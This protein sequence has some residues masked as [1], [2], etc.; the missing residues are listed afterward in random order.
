MTDCVLLVDDEAAVRTALAQ[1]MDLADIDATLAATGEEALAT[2][3][4]DWPGAVVTDMRMPGLSGL[5]LLAK[6]RDLDPD[7]PVVILT[8]QGD[9]PM[10][11]K[12]MTEGAYDFL[13]KPCP[14]DRLVEIVRHA[15]EKR[16]LVL[17][18][19]ALRDR[20]E[21]AEAGALAGNI[22]GEAAATRDYRARLIRVAEAGLDVLILGETGAGKELAARA[23][24][25]RSDRAAGPFVA[26]NCGALP[27]EL[28]A[29]ELLGH[30]KGAFTGA[31]ARRIGKFEHANGGAIFLDEIESMPRDLQVRLLR[32]LQERE[33]ERLGANTPV[34]LDIRVIAASKA[35]LKAEAAAGRFREDLFYRLDASRLRV[36]PLRERLED[37]PLLFRA[38]VEA[39]AARRGSAPPE[40]GP[41]L[42]MR[43]AAH[44]WPGN[45]RELKNAAERY[46]MGL[47]LQL[48]ADTDPAPKGLAEQV[49]AFERAALAEALRHAAG[50]AAEA[51]AALGLPRKTFYDKLTRHGLRAEDF[52]A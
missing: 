37:A 1:T 24:H 7:I 17:E 32:I 22:L 3:S 13:E 26:V 5:D 49:E 45:V 39:A 18:N 35:D 15:C 43:L 19:R 23:I 51:S 50:N 10:A 30:E 4:A 16:R 44:D 11:V 47:G 9:V 21:L 34:A 25:A 33:L 12:A 48:D 2:L 36:P 28:A 46:A 20:L 27:P 29:S 8:G 38:F 42:A 41:E 6:V 52:R 40:I 31:L 14:P